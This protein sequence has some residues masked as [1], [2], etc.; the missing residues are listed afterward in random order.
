MASRPAFP[1]EAWG[2]EGLRCDV[3]KAVSEI[4][5]DEVGWPNANFQPEDPADKVFF[6]FDCDGSF[7]DNC[8]I[9]GAICGIEYLLK[10]ELTQEELSAMWKRTFGD[11]IDMLIAKSPDAEIC[12]RQHLPRPTFGPG[13]LESEHCPSLAAFLDIRDFFARVLQI[14]RKELLPS[15]PIKRLAKG[16]G[17]QE[18]DQYVSGRFGVTGCVLPHAPWRRALK[19]GIGLT[20]A[21]AAGGL[22]CFPGLALP[23]AAATM[24]VALCIA[25]RRLPEAHRMAKYQVRTLGDLVKCICAERARKIERTQAR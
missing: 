5:R 1:D 23:I 25:L 11:A 9:E 12:L 18:I 15:T 16:S 7:Y 8:E 21:V 17:I 19:V 2:G 4:I 24:F 22:L 14:D 10:V 13:A 3:A 6:N 20:T